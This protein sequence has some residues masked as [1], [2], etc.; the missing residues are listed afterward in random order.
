MS[1]FSGSRKR[2]IR[3]GKLTFTH[4][5][6]FKLS[7]RVENPRKRSK[8][9]PGLEFDVTRKRCMVVP[10]MLPGIFGR[11]ACI[12]RAQTCQTVSLMMKMNTINHRRKR[13]PRTT[14][15][16]LLGQRWAIL[17]FRTFR[18]DHRRKRFWRRLRSNQRRQSLLG[19]DW[20]IV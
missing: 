19:V 5:T 14:R 17:K 13:R 16:L 4:Q 11:T 6:V 15:A 20:Y 10:R 2:K 3:P 18:T 12:I 1:E 8:L 7:N 9:A